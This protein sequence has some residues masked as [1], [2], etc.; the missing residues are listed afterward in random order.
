MYSLF[1][2]HGPYCIFYSL[3]LNY[4][5]AALV[6]HDQLV[7]IWLMEFLPSS[8]NIPPVLISP[9]NQPATASSFII[10]E[11]LLTRI[12]FLLLS[13][14]GPQTPNKS[15][16][17]PEG[18]LQSLPLQDSSA[19]QTRPTMRLQSE[20]H[21]QTGWVSGEAS[22]QASFPLGDSSVTQATAQ[23]DSERQVI[24]SMYDGPPIVSALSIMKAVTVPTNYI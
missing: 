8:G 12:H 2:S 10:D 4:F 20:T 24:S 13:R 14:N 3:P 1:A 9:N 17:L 5:I 18:S 22:I 23:G 6:H 21:Y 15:K 19:W 11:D 7:T 16:T